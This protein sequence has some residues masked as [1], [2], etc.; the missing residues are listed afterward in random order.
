MY[1][2]AQHYRKQLPF[3]SFI[4]VI[5]VKSILINNKKYVK[6]SF[7]YTFTSKSDFNFETIH[8]GVCR[9]KFFFF[10]LNQI[11][12]YYNIGWPDY[13]VLTFRWLVKDTDNNDVKQF[14]CKKLKPWRFGIYRDYR[15]RLMSDLQVWQIMF[16]SSQTVNNCI[17]LFRPS[18][19]LPICNVSY[20]CLWSLFI[21]ICVYSS[22]LV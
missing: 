11:L 1:T 22:Y 13:N 6:I 15:L 17:I 19:I 14:W 18:S 10:K 20:S 7:A 5:L 12:Y 8:V 9:Y 16:S 4:W 3:I 21:N 2:Y